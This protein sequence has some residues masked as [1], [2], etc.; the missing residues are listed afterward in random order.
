[1]KK[2]LIL[3]ALLVLLYSSAFSQDPEMEYYKSKE[4][5]TLL[6]RNRAGG[7]YGA[8]SVGYS[9]IDTYHALLFGGRFGWIA[10][11]SLGIGLGATGFI[12]EYHYESS[13]DKEVF[14]AGGYGG[15]YIE[16]ILLPRSPIHLS[17]PCLLGA[18]GISYVSQESNMNN[19][20][21]EDSETFLIAEPGVELELNLT[22]FFR[23]AVGATYRFPTAFNVGFSGTSTASSESLKGLSYMVTFKFGKF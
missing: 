7:G 5:K 21:I 13:I 12:N 11:H 19:N 6:G 4:I 8:F 16:P 15:L 14:L 2:S 23:L 1:M 10:S 9:E 22:R 17:F 18:G 20:L 3:S